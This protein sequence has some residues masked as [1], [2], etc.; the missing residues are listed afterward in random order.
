MKSYDVIWD[1]VGTYLYRRNFTPEDL[2][3]SL[4]SGPLFEKNIL[5]NAFATSIILHVHMKIPEGIHF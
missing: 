2:C 5:E 4:V 3:E 1:H